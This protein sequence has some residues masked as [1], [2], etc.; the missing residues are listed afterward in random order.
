[1][2]ILNPDALRIAFARVN[3]AAWR[4]AAE[5]GISAPTMTAYRHGK[6]CP[7][8]VIE[9]LAKATRST[10]EELTAPIAEQQA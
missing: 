3:R 4:V 10:P 1:M 9:A 6:P 8:E 5:I 2:K 7:K